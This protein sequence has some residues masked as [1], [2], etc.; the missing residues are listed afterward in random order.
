MLSIESRYIK[1]PCI[2]IVCEEH[3]D[4]GIAKWIYDLLLPKG[5]KVVL[6][7]NGSNGL[8][9]LES[10]LVDLIIAD[11][12]MPEINGVH[13]IAAATERYP[14]I[15]I[16]AL[17]TMA[18][19]WDYDSYLPPMELGASISMGKSRNVS[20]LYSMVMQEL[21]YGSLFVENTKLREHYSKEYSFS[22][23]ITKSPSMRQTLK[24][25]KNAAESPKTTISLTG[26]SGVGKE[27]LARAVHSESGIRCLPG[28]F[29]AVNCAAITEP[30]MESALFGHTRGSFTGAH[31]DTEGT[32]CKAR[33]G[34]LM[35][36][37]IGDMPLWLQA[38]LLRVLEEK[39]YEKVG[40][41][42]SLSADFRLITAT[43]RNLAEM[44]RQ[45]TFREDLFYR[46]NVVPI[47]IPPLRERKEDIPLLVKHFLNDMGKTLPGISPK[48]MDLLNSFSWPGNIRELRNALERA[49][50]VA[51]NELIKA[52]HL[53]FLNTP[54]TPG[55]PGTNT[56]NFNFDIPTE[57]LSLKEIECKVLEITLERCGGNKAKAA[58]LLKISRSDFYR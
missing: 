43:H 52:E 14:M 20:E 48:A 35:L 25:A 5:F 19:E 2:L 45:G 18:D 10:E 46:I 36:D 39:C 54:P 44:V 47:V 8:S 26:E 34:T 27:K 12:N 28:N 29:A 55:T 23:I 42:K 7:T 13:F 4:N 58:K 53:Q 33:G 57:G 24:L 15:P 56:V 6:A 21:V 51:P 50:I 32:F 40:S 41:T 16:I 49:S 38:K 3:A 37:E 22:N 17:V 11:F 1:K 9:I 30:L 31:K